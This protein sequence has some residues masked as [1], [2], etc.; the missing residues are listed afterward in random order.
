MRVTLEFSDEEEMDAAQAMR[1]REMSAFIWEFQHFLRGIWK[2]REIETEEG[3][4]LIDEIWQRWHE[5]K[6]EGLE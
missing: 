1:W 5:E 2:H 3:N 4:I 6:P